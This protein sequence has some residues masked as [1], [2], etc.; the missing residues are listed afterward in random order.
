M[1]WS[2][3]SQGE[4]WFTMECCPIVEIA[5]DFFLHFDCQTPFSVFRIPGGEKPNAICNISFLFRLI[6]KSLGSHF[7][8]RNDRIN[9]QNEPCQ[10]PNLPVFLLEELFSCRYRIF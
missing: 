2:E 3:S 4:N 10:H 8:N 5:R 9:S 7:D 1:F 6:P